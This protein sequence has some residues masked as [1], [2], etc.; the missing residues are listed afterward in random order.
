MKKHIHH[1][2]TSDFPVNN[3]YKVPL[4]N[5]KIP[6]KFKDE[7]NSEIFTEF[8]GLRSKMYTVLS[9]KVEKMKKAKGV[10]K[11]VLKR[12]IDFNDFL[13]CIAFKDHTVDVQQNSFRT[14]H[15]NVY[16][17]QQQKVGLSAAD[18]KRI[19]ADDNIHTFS[20]GHYNPKL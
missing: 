16:T 18:D 11:G 14:L 20:Y 2:D 1:Y 17:I 9:G 15:H 4:E 7:L 8:V 13:A 5:K 19:I 6:G 12:Q 3:K 10:K